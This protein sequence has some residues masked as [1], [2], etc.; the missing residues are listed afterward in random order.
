M[1]TEGEK[2]A[3]KTVLVRTG[4]LIFAGFTPAPDSAA[5]KE[6]VGVGFTVCSQECRE[7]LSSNFPELR[8]IQM[9]ELVNDRMN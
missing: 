7:K 3:G 6:G 2:L 9:Q 8:N 1:H 4:G 5:E